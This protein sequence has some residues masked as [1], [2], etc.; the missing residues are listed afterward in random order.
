MLTPINV[1]DPDTADCVE[2]ARVFI[3]R[4]LTLFWYRKN[5]GECEMPVE[6]LVAVAQALDLFTHP[7]RAVMRVVSNFAQDVLCCR[8]WQLAGFFPY[9]GGAPRVGK[10]ATMEAAYRM[11]QFDVTLLFTNERC[12]SVVTH[13]IDFEHIRVEKP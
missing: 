6:K 12:S 10:K 7:R 5:F 11:N 3:R 4:M 13:C 8:I 9:E 2:A 1:R